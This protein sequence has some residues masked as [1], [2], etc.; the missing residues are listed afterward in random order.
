VLALLAQGLR[1]VEIAERLVLWSRTVDHHVSSV[2]GQLGVRTRG[3][4]VV[5][6]HRLG[7]TEDR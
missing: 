2:L 7:L 3:E 6:A 1:N 5:E 4:A